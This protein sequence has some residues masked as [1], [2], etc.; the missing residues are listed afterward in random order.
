MASVNYSFSPNTVAQSSQVSSNFSQLASAILPTF[1]FTIIGNLSTGTN[2]TPVVLVPASL[3]IIKAYAVVKTA[4][5]G[6]SIL[7]D[8]NK[9]GTSIWSATQGNRL[10][11]VA[12]ATTGNQTSFD[13]VQLAENDQ[14]TIDL[15]QIGSVTN[16]S[17]VTIELKCEWR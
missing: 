10:T 2:L 1:V 7:I 15:D 8:I 12:T 3:T 13:T 6:A 16:G 14:L 11:V 9:N 17:D 5:G 4:P